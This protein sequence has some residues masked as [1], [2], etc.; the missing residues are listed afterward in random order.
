MARKSSAPKFS[1]HLPAPSYKGKVSLTTSIVIDAPIEKVWEIILDFQSFSEWYT[2]KRVADQTPREGS[3]LILD[4]YA[5][6]TDSPKAKPATRPLERIIELDEN[7][8]RIAWV[9]EG[10][11]WLL[12][13][14]RWQA[15]SVVEG[16]KTL[17]ETREVMSGPLSY[18]VRWFMARNLQKGF[19][20]SGECLKKRAEELAAKSASA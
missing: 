17:Y 4:V 13:A 8:H 7:A 11:Q 19:N 10:P 1:E 2:K 18:V 12:R 6:P 15:L 14:E 9:G 20:A 3:Y 16:G 5:P